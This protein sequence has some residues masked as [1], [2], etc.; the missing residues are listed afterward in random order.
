M[1]SEANNT[2]ELEPALRYLAAN[3]DK[4]IEFIVGKFQ[5]EGGKATLWAWLTKFNAG[6]KQL[7]AHRIDSALAL[8]TPPQAPAP[9]IAAVVKRRAAREPVLPLP[10]A[11]DPSTG[12]DSATNFPRP[13]LTKKFRRDGFKNWR[14]TLERLAQDTTQ[15]MVALCGGDTKQAMSFTAFKANWLGRGEVSAAAVQEFIGYGNGRMA[16]F[17]TPLAKDRMEAL[18]KL[19]ATDVSQHIDLEAL[20]KRWT[21]AKSDSWQELELTLGRSAGYALRY[22]GAKKNPALAIG[23]LAYAELRAAGTPLKAGERLRVLWCL[24]D[25]CLVLVPTKSAGVLVTEEK[26][27]L[28]MSCRALQALLGNEP[29]IFAVSLNQADWPADHPDAAHLFVEIPSKG[30]AT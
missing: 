22:S 7:S 29:R 9:R 19:A 11:A 24:R 5:V 17:A 6:K 18:S 1:S 14:S 16:A 30:G 13:W 27:G 8:A 25:K 2:R 3:P 28:R 21:A 23:K 20:A 10:A 15:S 12:R 26:G 4:K